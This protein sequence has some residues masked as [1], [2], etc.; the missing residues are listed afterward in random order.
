VTALRPNFPL[1]KLEGD[2]ALTFATIDGIDGSML[3]DTIDN[4]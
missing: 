1:A 4:L 2:A 3:L